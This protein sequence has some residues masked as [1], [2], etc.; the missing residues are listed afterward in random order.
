M[1]NLEEKYKYASAKQLQVILNEAKRKSE[2]SGVIGNYYKYLYKTHLIYIR[3][4]NLSK[5]K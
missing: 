5:I 4:R 1:A 3:N 2:M